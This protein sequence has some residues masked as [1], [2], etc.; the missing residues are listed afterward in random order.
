MPKTEAASTEMTTKMLEE[1]GAAEGLSAL[2]SSTPAEIPRGVGIREAIPPIDEDLVIVDEAFNPVC[3]LALSNCQHKLRDEQQGAP[4]LGRTSSGP[5]D[6]KPRFQSFLVHIMKF[7]LDNAPARYPN[8][9]AEAHRAQQP[10]L[11]S[12]HVGSGGAPPGKTDQ[13][14]VGPLFTFASPTLTTTVLT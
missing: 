11:S 9:I 4:P 2:L 8:L 6:E 14:E 12:K 1:K 3:Q 5:G 10:S 13:C 7:L